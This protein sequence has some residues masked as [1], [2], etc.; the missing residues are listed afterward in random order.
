M[1]K[2]AFCYFLFGMFIQSEAQKNFTG[3][4]EGKM[5]IGVNIGMAF[6]FIKDATGNYEG[7]INSPDLHAEA[8]AFSDVKIFDDSIAASI[9]IMNAIFNGRLKNDSVLSGVWTQNGHR[10][11]L[12]LKKIATANFDKPQTPKPPFSYNSEDVEFDN[13]D[14]S[15]HFGATFTYPKTGDVFTTA[16]LITGSGQQDRDETI[17]NHKPFAVI[18]DYLTKKGYAVL[19]IDDRGIGKTTGNVANATT[20]DFAK[21]IEAAIAYIKTRKETDTAKLGL[22]GHSEGALI[23]DMIA[24]KDTSISFVI[25]LAAPGL[26][27]TEILSQQNEA[28]LKSNNVSDKTAVAYKNLY[29]AVMNDVVTEKD[30]SLLMNNAWKDYL[31]WKKQQDTVIINELEIRSDAD[32][33][34]IINSLV[35]GL[36]RPWLKYFIATNPAEYIEIFRC[37]VLALNGEKDVQIAAQPNLIAIKAALEKSKAKKFDVKQLPGLNHLFQHCITCAVNEYAS[38]KESFAPEALTEI[39]NWLDANIMH[40]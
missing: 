15:V 6:H 23:A 28:L 40:N 22:I 32:A 26:Q 33:K 21:D 10:F 7:A 14:K 5:N 12:T 9:Q 25:M 34:Q 20:A 39:S 1:K 30:S 4:W 18:A 35:K 38:L 17:F 24:A 29:A 11:P 8:I 16:I 13:S 2:I 31:N 3:I 37:K 36:S 19:R 27:G